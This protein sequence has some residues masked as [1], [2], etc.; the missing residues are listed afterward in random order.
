MELMSKIKALVLTGGVEENYYKKIKKDITEGNCMIVRYF[1]CVAV[2]LLAILVILSFIVKSLSGFRPVYGI[3]FFIS[4]LVWGV[5]TFVDEKNSK[6]QLINMYVFEALLL[7]IGLSLGTYMG[8]HETSATYIAFLLTVPQLFTDR[9]YRMYFLI[10][11]SVAIFIALVIGV[12]DPATWSSDITNA[13][14]FGFFSLLL[15][16]Y[17]ISTRLNRYVLEYKIRAL[18]ANDQLTGLR[19]RYSYEQSLEKIP[20]LGA[21]SVYCVY[22]DVNGLHEMNNTLG[23]EAGDRMLKFIASRM[24]ETFG[25]ENAYRIGG[26]EF[27][28]LGINR[29]REDVEKDVC[30]LQKV[31]IDEGY[32]VA[33]GIAYEAKS[34]VKMD[35]LV[36]EA[37][38]AMY[39]DKARYYRENGI[40]RRRKR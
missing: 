25:K 3:A 31:V 35:M 20:V 13:L 36:K 2:F 10:L 40:D 29:P 38:H 9:P 26:D 27:V 15:C 14:L 17:S 7:A 22:V 8:P 23:H 12:K 30:T 6:V 37:E 16:T 4:T 34:S 24:Q 39:T 28:V 21:E 11:G 33:A 32:H 19:N 1:S 5:S 18:A